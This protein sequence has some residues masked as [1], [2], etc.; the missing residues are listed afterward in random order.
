MSIF[1]IFEESIL[2]LRTNKMRTGLSALGIIIG[3]ASVITLMSLG[4][5]SQ[6]SIKQRIQTLGSNLLTVRPGSFQQGFLRGNSEGGKTLTNED[7]VAIATSNRITTV[8]SVAMEYSSRSQVLYLRNNTNSQ[9]IGVTAG[10]ERLRNIEVSN[11][12]FIS[13]TDNTTLQKVA[14]LGST[15][16]KTLFGDEDPLGKNIRVN[17]I[18]FRVV[19]VTKEKGASGGG[20]NPDES[21]YIP[22]LT[23]QKSLYGVD[24]LSTI[25]VEA[26]DENSME[27]ARNQIGFLLLERHR[28]EKVEDADFSIFSQSDILETANSITETFTSLLTGIAAISLIVGGIGIMNIMLVT[29]T[30]R[31]TEIG[32]RK[33]LGAKKKA[34]IQQFLMESLVLTVLG[35]LVGILVGVGSS[36]ALTKAMSLPFTLSGTSIGLAFI[37]SSLIGVVF[38]WYPAQK[39]S[40]LQ[41]IEALRYE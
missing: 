19:G 41:P 2:V 33:A 3:I 10:Y 24:Y 21:V 13:E 15:V 34:I 39:A 9:I 5:A 40:N 16:T 11:G 25:Y 1:E 32:L 31:T 7:A 28:K 35:G 38:G 29:V 4:S 22:L 36:Y 23:A 12:A 18:T 20:G 30:E 26:K 17:G 8:N 27:G 6:A 14:V 37:V